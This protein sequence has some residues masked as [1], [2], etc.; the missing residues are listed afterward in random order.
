M[1]RVHKVEQVRKDARWIQDAG[2]S[3]GDV[4]KK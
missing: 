1:T 3:R 2:C 4:T